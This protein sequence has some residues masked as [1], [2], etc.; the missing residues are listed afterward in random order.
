MGTLTVL[1]PYGYISQIRNSR[2]DPDACSF[3]VMNY[4]EETETTSWRI[5][6]EN[7][8]LQGMRNFGPL[9]PFGLGVGARV[10]R[11][12]AKRISSK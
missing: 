4:G 8:E 7:G 1:E 10:F 5:W 12:E 11:I 9:R 6:T 3:E 2:C